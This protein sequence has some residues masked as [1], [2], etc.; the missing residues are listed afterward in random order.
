MTLSNNFFDMFWKGTFC[1]G[2]IGYPLETV[3]MSI[4]KKSLENYYYTLMTVYCTQ[5]E[6]LFY[7]MVTGDTTFVNQNPVE[8]GTNILRKMNETN[9]N[10]TMA[11]K[12]LA[13]MF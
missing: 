11:F 4:Q 10:P 1:S 6:S 8:N 2:Q 3:L 12:N 7:L 9:M 5:S 13:Y